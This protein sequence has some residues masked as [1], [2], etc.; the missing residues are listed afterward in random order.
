MVKCHFHLIARFR[1]WASYTSNDDYVVEFFWP[2]T[3]IEKSK[4]L[5]LDILNDLKHLKPEFVAVK[6][7]GVEIGFQKEAISNIPTSSNT[8]RPLKIA[9]EGRDVHAIEIKGHIEQRITKRTWTWKSKRKRLPSEVW[10]HFV[11]CENVET[12]EEKSRCIHCSTELTRKE[13]SGTKHMK[14]HLNYHCP[15]MK[16]QNQERSRLNFV[17]MI[18]KHGYPLDMADQ[19]FFKNFV[20]DMQPMFEFQ[21]KD[22]S[23]YIRSIY[24]EEKEKLQLYF[25][26]LGSKFNLT[27]S[28]WKNNSGK[29]AYCCLMAHFID[30]SWELKMKT[31][32]L[33][34]LEDIYDTKAVVG[35]IQSLVSEWNI[36]SKVCS[37]TVDN[38][39]LNDSMVRQIKEN[40]L[41]DQGSLSSARWFI[42][43]TLLE[44]GFREMDGILYKLKNSIKYVTETRHG[45]LKFQEALNQVKLQGGKS[46]DDLSFKLESD[47][48][49]LDSALRSREIFCKL[50]Q[51]D[52]NFMLNLSMEEWEKAVTLQS[53]FKCFD[54]IKGTQSLTANLY[55][56]KLCNMYGEFGQLK[57]CNHPFAILMKRKF[58]YYWSLCNLAFTIASVLDP[59]LKFR[60][61]DNEIYDLENKMKMIRFRKVLL[62]VYSEYANEA[63]NLTASSSALDDSNSS[64]TE[65]TK[66]YIMSYFSKFASLND[67]EEVASQ[68]SEFDYYLDEPL[69]PSDANILSWWCVNSQRFPTLAKMARDFLAMPVSVSA[70]SSNISAMTINRAYSSLD[71]ESMEAL[72]C[73]QNWLETTKENDGEHHG[74]MQNMDKRKRKMK[75]NDTCTVKVSKN[76]NNEKASSNG[77]IASDSNK[78]DHSL[79]FDNW[80]EPQCSSSESVGEKAAIMEASVRNRNRLESS[81]GKPNHGSNIAAS[82]QISNDEPLLNNNQLDQFQSSSSE[83]DDETTLKDKRSW[84]KED[85][86]TYLV[87]SFTEKEKKR[88]NKWRM[89]ELSG[90]L[91]GRD[92]EFKLK[93]EKL[94]PLLMVPRSDETRLEYYIDDSVV[95]TFFRLLKKRSD[96]FSKTYIDHYS[97]DPQ[98]AT[99]L[100]TGSKLKQEVLDWFKDE[101]LRGVHKM[102]LPMCLSAHWILFYVDTKKKK[103]SWLD[104][105]PSSRMSNKVEKKI[106]LQWFTT[107]LLPEY[108]YNDAKEWPF[109]VR[110]DIPEQKNSVDCGV[111]VMKYADCLMH[112]EFFPF[113]QEDMVHF[114]HRI[115]LD[116]YRERL[117]GKK[118]R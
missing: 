109:I 91:I 47:S 101:K 107:F 39:F 18:I 21:S 37:I 30:D 113:T 112:G 96:R 38:S 74:P 79:S 52:D 80:I 3:K 97:F 102:F 60:F 87:S 94:A 110:T 43:F 7:Q 53:C 17:K 118:Y 111:F 108:G 70:P 105:R 9:E 31:L 67:V 93:G 35:I 44:D 40:C 57:K 116:I 8:I 36:G 49:I 4:S 84:R 51:I 88:L 1:P 59:R 20:K 50:E 24:K 25:D 117:H 28:L 86:R 104:P 85:V 90:K 100:I 92:E 77:D 65:T 23:S 11:K 32:G 58:D 68:K 5:A 56:P 22:I 10:K 83:S 82:I 61:S 13:K 29:T 98:I 6:I 66:D 27:V 71:P 16:I 76:R 42:S 69:L 48:G 95:S 103:I 14:N 64:T 45:K 115:F 81:I 54:D 41:N 2:A 12:G 26:K 34:T 73:S 75:E 78:N 63:K 89:S 19:E 55:F 33:R 114:R 15:V 106:I 72:V 46:W 99:F 62:D